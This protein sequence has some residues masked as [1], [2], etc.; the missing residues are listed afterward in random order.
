MVLVSRGLIPSWIDED[1]S[2]QMPQEKVFNI[3]YK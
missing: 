3:Y 2:L 1:H